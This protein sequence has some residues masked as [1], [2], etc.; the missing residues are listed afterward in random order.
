MHIVTTLLISLNS[1]I[2]VKRATQP[3]PG[4]QP[5]LPHI[6]VHLPKLPS[7]SGASSLREQ[8]SR[9]QTKWRCYLRSWLHFEPSGA[10]AIPLSYSS[11]SHHWDSAGIILT[12]CKE[13][14]VE[15]LQLGKEEH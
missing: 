8:E 9:E 6:A 5:S 4:S 15:R 11:L 10:E 2:L 3:F 14:E 1:R 7:S 13:K 12:T